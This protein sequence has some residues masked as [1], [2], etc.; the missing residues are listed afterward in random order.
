MLLISVHRL[1][2]IFQNSR[3]VPTPARR[4]LLAVAV[5]FAQLAV[6]NLKSSGR[7]PKNTYIRASFRQIFWPTASW[8]R[9]RDHCLAHVAYLT[10]FTPP[11]PGGGPGDLGPRSACSCAAAGRRSATGCKGGGGNGCRA[12]SGFVYRRSRKGAPA[13]VAT[14]TKCAETVKAGQDLVRAAAQLR[15]LLRLA[16]VAQRAV[17]VAASPVGGDA[18][19]P[20]VL[21]RLPA[22]DQPR[23]PAPLVSAKKFTRR[24][25]H[26]SFAFPLDL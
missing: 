1:M 3:I 24:D 6:E 25:L 19:P 2:Q 16:D 14:K 23:R 26:V 7:W 9:P 20:S 21:R 12:A 10:T 22:E 18:G 13:R 5:G 8:P 17:A 11:S 15:R 4:R